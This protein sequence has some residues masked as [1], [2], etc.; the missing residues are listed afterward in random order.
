MLS[1]INSSNVGDASSSH[2]RMR[3]W[4]EW[5]SFVSSLS[6][7]GYRT[8]IHL[9]ATHCDFLP[10]HTVKHELVPLMEQERRTIIHKLNA[11][12]RHGDAQSTLTND[13][14]S[15]SSRVYAMDYRPSEINGSVSALRHTLL[16]AAKD[17]IEHGIVPASYHRAEQRIRTEIAKY[18]IDS[19]SDIAA[20]ADGA[21]SSSIVPLITDP[22][23]LSLTNMFDVCS[24]DDDELAND[25]ALCR[26]AVSNNTHGR[27]NS[28]DEMDGEHCIH[29]SYHMYIYSIAWLHISLMCVLLQ[30]SNIV[31]R[32][33]WCCYQ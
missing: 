9:V 8:P 15:I 22:P 20:C 2:K 29:R 26:R 6:A 27:E 14:V 32:L 23:I 10:A 4:H 21:D 5:S 30:R 24:A 1:D 17:M 13:R 33:D 28:R 7:T 25:S 12:V 16:T 31:H 18:R 19:S 11:L 3:E